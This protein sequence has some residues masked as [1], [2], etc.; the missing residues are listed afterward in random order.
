MGD[1]D[2]GAGT[3]PSDM[4]IDTANS[5]EVMTDS[6]ITEQHTFECRGSVQPKLLNITPYK[7][8]ACDSSQK[9]ELDSLNNFKN[10]NILSNTDDVTNNITNTPA[11][12]VLKQENQGYYKQ[13]NQQYNGC[14]YNGGLEQVT[15]EMV[16]GI[17]L[18]EKEEDG[19]Y[20]WAD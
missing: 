19:S 15:K 18:E 10:L 2:F 5:E 1:D 14:K 7:P 11:I 9:Y 16:P 12:N 8:Q 20:Q 13:R 17:I 3:N 6:R 4:S